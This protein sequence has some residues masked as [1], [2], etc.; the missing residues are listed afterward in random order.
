MNLRGWLTRRNLIIAMVLLTVV[1]ATACYFAL[2]RPTPVAMERYVPAASLA[3]LEIDNL[4]DLFD[5]LTSTRAWRELGPAFGLSSQLQQIGLMT[6]L[7]GRT[8][9]GP[10][11]AVLAGRAQL[12]LALTDLEAETGQTD[13][14]PYLH[15]KPRLALIIETHAPPA[16]AAR[17]VN[18]RA[19]IVAQRIYGMGVRQEEQEYQGARL[20][21]FRDAKSDRPLVAAAIGSVIVLTNHLEAMR[22]SLDTIAG[23]S[24]AMAEDAGLAR[25]KPDVGGN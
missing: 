11:E 25:L 14:G 8:G 18:E 22:A 13:E 19:M 17:L 3:F 1:V 6:D 16:A 12:A 15:F 7:V 24:P 5:G 10:D 20:L 21:V 9:L 4:A 2:R 23:R